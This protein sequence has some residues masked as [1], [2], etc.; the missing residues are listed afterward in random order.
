MKSDKKQVVLNKEIVRGFVGS[1]LTSGFD[2]A[3]ESPEFHDECWELCTSKHKYVAI[4]A[5]RG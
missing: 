2:G 5:P 3:V 1:L 4:G